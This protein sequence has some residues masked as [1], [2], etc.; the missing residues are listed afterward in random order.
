MKDKFRARQLGIPF[1]GEPGPY[2]AITDVA[3]VWVGHETLIYGKGKLE[4]GVGPVRTG[5][6]AV[7]PRG[8]DFD[9]IFA[10]WYS[11][12]GCGEM[13]GTTWLEE[14]GF[15]QSPVML[16]NTFSV[17]D[18]STA[19][20][21]W[22]VHKFQ[23]PIWPPL[24]TETYDGFLNDIQGLHVKQKHVWAALDRAA[25]GAMEEGAVGGGTG[26]IC[27]GFKGGIGTASR[28]LS[29]QDG[30]FM[31]GVLVQANHGRQDNLHIAGV[32][33]GAE[34]FQAVNNTLASSDDTKTSSIIVI[35]ATDCPLLPH[36]LKRLARR[37]PLGVGIVGGRGENY[38]G[39]LFLAFSTAR[40]G[41]KDEVGLR[42]VSMLANDRM[43]PLFN[44]VVQATEEAIVNALVAAETM[45]GIN[46]FTVHAIP[47]QPLQAILRRH[48]RLA[49]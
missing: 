22:G 25:S 36:Q 16:T 20:H 40:I 12:N 15:L 9:G 17:G 41:A 19:V 6:T 8:Y 38:S 11:L 48:Q 39:D 1:Q 46:D 29:P 7:L 3:G 37:A 28:R 31:L 2:N 27:H 23:R 26:M 44:A 42:A 30:G 34:L 45:D 49:E 24:V 18:V 32:P 14:S 47:H 33:V 5:V 43:D 13:T 10:A 4:T 35:I 21:S